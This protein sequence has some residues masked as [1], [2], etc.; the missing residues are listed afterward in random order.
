MASASCESDWG[1]TLS[2]DLIDAIRRHAEQLDAQARSVEELAPDPARETSPQ[3]VDRGPRL[4]RPA[5]VAIAVAVI[6]IAF[7][8]LVVGNLFSGEEFADDTFVGPPSSST[9]Q[10]VDPSIVTF[11]VSHSPLPY[12]EGNLGVPFLAIDVQVDGGGQFNGVATTDADGQ[13]FI[14]AESIG[15]TQEQVSAPLGGDRITIR[16]GDFVETFDTF[17]FAVILADPPS[18]TVVL[19]AQMPQGTPVVVTLIDGDATATVETRVESARFPIDVSGVFDITEATSIEARVSSGRVTYVTLGGGPRHSFLHVNLADR[20]L[21]GQSFTPGAELTV[22][23]DGQV[24]DVEATVGSAGSWGFGS[25]AFFESL[26][27]G[28]VVSVSDDYR[29]LSVTVQSIGLEFEEETRIIGGL[30]SLPD[31]SILTVNVTQEGVDLLVS[32]VE[33]SGGTW[34]LEVPGSIPLST[35]DID[36]FWLDRSNEAGETGVVIFTRG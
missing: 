8:P 32:Q 18:D 35:L 14:S 10:T 6:V 21:D 22:E 15:Q 33:V 5:A 36:V 28:Q 31:G 24:V 30:T 16:A 9:T 29:T 13:F 19:E 25:G 2:F 7:V 27:P 20:M 3:R 26:V 17:E 4:A 23:V 1:W 12:I 11:E 34:S